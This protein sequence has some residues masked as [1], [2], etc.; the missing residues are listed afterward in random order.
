MASRLRKLAPLL[1]LGCCG[2]ITGGYYRQQLF[3]PVAHETVASL[4]IGKSTLAEALHALGAPLLVWEWKGE[5][6]ALAWGWSDAAR[7]GFAVSVPVSNS[8]SA[9]AFSWDSV[10]SNLPGAVL[11]FGPDDVLLEAREGRLADIRAETM[12]PRPAPP[13]EALP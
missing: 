10:A 3:A 9:T 2:C 5:G 6:A 11:F 13:A 12:Q 4:E 8:S 1:A 7:W